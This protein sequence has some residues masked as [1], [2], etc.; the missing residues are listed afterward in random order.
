M[1]KL[2]QKEERIVSIFLQN[3][4]MQSSEVHSKIMK[5]GEEIS[6]VTIK[7]TLTKMVEKGVLLVKGLGRSTA[8]ELS[9]SGRIFAE[10]DR[11]SVV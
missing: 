9:V 1:I 7:R 5:L 3:R 8:Y 2:N 10:V 4:K 6:L 11:K